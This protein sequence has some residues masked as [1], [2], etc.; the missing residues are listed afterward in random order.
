MF[1]VRRKP[2]NYPFNSTHPEIYE[3]IGTGDATEARKA[4]ICDIE[5]ARKWISDFGR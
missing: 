5:S 3:A 2:E 4:M 1:I